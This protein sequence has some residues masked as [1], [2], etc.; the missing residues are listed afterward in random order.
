MP[1]EDVPSRIEHAAV[2]PE[3]TP[4]DV[5]SVLDD[6][7]EYGMAAR[8]PP[9]YVSLADSYAPGVRLTTA[10]GFP[11]GQNVPS[12][13][14]AEAERAQADGADELAVVANVGRLKATEDQ[15]VGEDL[16]EVIAATALPV[17]VIVEAPLLSENELDRI[18]QLAA[19]AG[20]DF[21]ETATGFA[22]GGATVADV[23]H[24]ARFLPVTASGGVDSWDRAEAMFEAGAA[25]LCSTAGDGIVE[26]YRRSH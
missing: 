24:L 3:T 17:T 15:G 1:Y 21:L 4:E 13:K 11:H 8:V 16:A 19:E 14:A 12:V 25:R 10:V 9:C 23:E 2:G 26:E 6:A 5:I 18:A 20:A 22:D 7:I